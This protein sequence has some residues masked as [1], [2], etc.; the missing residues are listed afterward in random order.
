MP[1][2]ILTGAVNIGILKQGDALNLNKKLIHISRFLSNLNSVGK[3]QI[4]F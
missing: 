4:H 3:V 1:D 2:K